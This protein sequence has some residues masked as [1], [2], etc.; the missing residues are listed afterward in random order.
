MRACLDDLLG[1]VYSLMYAKHYKF[2][3]RPQ[4]LSE[5]DIGNVLVRARKMAV[6]RMRIE[7]KWT[8]GF[9]FNNGLFRT[10]AVYHRALKILTGSEDKLEKLL[11]AAE[12]LYEHARK[13]PWASESVKSV[14]DEVNNLKHTSGG[15]SDG[16][17]VQFDTAVKAVD[18][19]LELIEALK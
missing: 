4:A 15:I 14:H 13:I 6:A 7:G 2:S 9:Y 8:A 17:D 10:S 12:K 18:E 5:K 3:S 19:I 16:R 11:S 1:A